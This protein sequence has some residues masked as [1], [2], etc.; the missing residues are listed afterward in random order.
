MTIPD[1]LRRAARRTPM[2]GRILRD[3]DRLVIQRDQLAALAAQLSGIQHQVLARKSA[4]TLLLDVRCLVD[5]HTFWN[6][7]WEREHLDRMMAVAQALGGDPRP[8]LFLDIGAFWGL[9]ALR[10][11]GLGLFDR[12]ICFEPDRTNAAQ[13]GAQ[14]F[15]NDACYA[16][17]VDRR[18]VSDRAGRARFSRSGEQ[19]EG[20][21]GSARFTDTVEGSD[22]VE[23]VRLDDV[24]EVT[25]HLVFI[26]L[27]VETHEAAA[28]EGMARLLASNDVYLQIESFP[29]QF[30]TVKSRIPTRLRHRLSR[31]VD[32]VFSSFELPVTPS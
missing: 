32:H 18:A 10:A 27:D 11:H 15:L 4:G 23:T 28:L 29:D 22:I 2:L 24:L 3:R 1:W 14:L 21:R 8:K 6:D 7:D 13:L 20:N 16:I 31:G 25:D 5:Q 12:I 26:K 9:Y 19:P 30:E 17:E